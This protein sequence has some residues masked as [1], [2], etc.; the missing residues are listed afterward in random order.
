ML[1]DDDILPPRALAKHAD[2]LL[3][4]RAASFSYGRFLRFKGSRP[5][6][7]FGQPGRRVRPS[8][9]SAPARV[10]LMENCFLTNPTWA[11]RREA[12]AKAGLYDRRLAYSQDYEMVLRYAK[13]NEGVFIDDHLLYQRK[14]ESLRGPRSEQARVTDT[15]E[16]W[17]KYDRLIFE[18]ID[19]SWDI[20]DFRPFDQSASPHGMRRIAISSKGGDPFSAQSLRRRNAGLGGISACA[21]QAR[22]PTRLE[23]P[24]AAGLL[25]CRYGNRRSAQRR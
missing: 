9:R 2:A 6:L 15:I 5:A 7:S 11:V 24:I 16:K 25:G 23:Y 3:R 19:R 14:H 12:Q 20:A 22:P 8:S 17:I 18:E 13:E 4:S 21:R 1:D 10:K